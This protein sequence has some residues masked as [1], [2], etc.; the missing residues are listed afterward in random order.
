[1]EELSREGLI[2]K[3][4]DGRYEL[5]EKGRQEAGWAYWGRRP[6]PGS[7]EEVLNEL[8]SYISY[9]EDLKA[10]KAAEIANQ[11]SRIRELADKLSKLAA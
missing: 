2:Q 10:S 8:S 1:L 6:E 11:S 7:V 4:G 3:R 9:L 5:T